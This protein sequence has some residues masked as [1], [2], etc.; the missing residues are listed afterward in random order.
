MKACL[1]LHDW[2][3][4]RVE[5]HVSESSQPIEWKLSQR[6]PF[7]FEP[8]ICWAK[9][10][11]SSF[12]LWPQDWTQNRDQNLRVTIK[13][14]IAR[15]SCKWCGEMVIDRVL[16]DECHWPGFWGIFPL[17][18]GYSKQFVK[19]GENECNNSLPCPYLGLPRGLYMGR[20]Y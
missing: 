4:F 8:L 17:P 5:W 15:N 12:W 19:P 18:S 11:G 13:K 7:T 20:L 14:R 6:P 1:L 10:L 9:L 2:K 16:I 3:T